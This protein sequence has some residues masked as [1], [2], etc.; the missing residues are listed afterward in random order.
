VWY[1]DPLLPSAAQQGDPPPS[2][3]VSEED[4]EWVS[5]SMA[6]ARRA[7]AGALMASATLATQA[8]ALT[9]A[10][11]RQ[12]TVP[13]AAASITGSAGAGVR[14]QPINAGFKQPR[15]VIA[16]AANDLP[17]AAPT[18]ALD[19][20]GFTARVSWPV[21]APV[22]VIVDAG[23][24]L[25]AHALDDDGF[26]ARLSWPVP[27]VP[28]V[29][30]DTDEV[31]ILQ[32]FEE[33]A[34]FAPRPALAVRPVLVVAE[35][36]D[37]PAAPSVALEHNDAPVL[38]AVWPLTAPV[39]AIADDDDLPVTA[40]PATALDDEGLGPI[41]SHAPTDFLVSHP[42]GFG[43]AS[44][45]FV[46]AAEQDDAPALRVVW[47]VTPRVRAITDDEVLPFDAP[48]PDPMTGSAGAGIRVQ[49]LNAGFKRPPAPFTVGDDLPTGVAPS[50]GVDEERGGVFPPPDLWR[51][52]RTVF[53]ESDAPVPQPIRGDEEGSVILP[54]KAWPWLAH[55]FIDDAEIA[56][57]PTPIGVTED[58][59]FPPRPWPFIAPRV[60]SGP[61]DESD[62]WVAP[63][64]VPVLPEYTKH[65]N[66]SSMFHP[67]RR[68]R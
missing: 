19:E 35:E 17:P 57:V 38:R 43:A 21:A 46:R 56:S 3:V 31:A 30:T 68:Y 28:R 50:L 15:A 41:R 8:G 13:T 7:M 58:A 45:E 18:V 60:R 36:D 34:Y 59:Y 61:E 66:P 53:A 12:D 4:G 33:D 54:A 2:P 27:T 9:M 5:V 11:G 47:P 20:D 39:R 24:D 67:R 42:T 48:P 32:A 55:P 40:A 62:V 37:L 65:R 25:P 6:G 51:T 52:N 44:D 29:V 63:P 16:D 49:P 10:D 1:F 14:V 26:L 23:D 22:R 64:V